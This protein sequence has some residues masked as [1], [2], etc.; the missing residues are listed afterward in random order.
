MQKCFTTTEIVSKKS[1]MREKRR[2]I[3]FR[4][5][6]FTSYFFLFFTYPYEH[7]TEYNINKDRTKTYL[8]DTKK[9]TNFAVAII[10]NNVERPYTDNFGNECK[11]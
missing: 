9:I 2:D 4:F 6:K 10:E 8:R 11:S 5:S 3:N 1:S 7:K